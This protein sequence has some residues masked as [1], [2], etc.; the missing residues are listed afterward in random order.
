LVADN[1]PLLVFV[2]GSAADV[3]TAAMLSIGRCQQLRDLGWKL[4]LQVC[5]ALY[6][7][8]A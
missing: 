6:S 1:K 3:A 7:T 2:Q 8:A 4:L 5:C